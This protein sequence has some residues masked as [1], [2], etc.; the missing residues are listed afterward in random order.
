MSYELQLPLSKKLTV[1][2]RVEPGCLGPDGLDHVESFC[3]Y[4]KHEV[5]DFYS[6]F[7]QW[8]ITPRYDKTLVETEYTTNNKRLSYDKAEKYLGVFGNN[9]EEFEEHIHEKLSALIDKY[10]GR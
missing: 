6:D 3:L 10:L 8:V 7:V 9:V 5:I 1:T 4:A 2:L